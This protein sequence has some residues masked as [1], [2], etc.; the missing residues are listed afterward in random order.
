MS[1]LR[2]LSAVLLALALVAGAALWLQWQTTDNLRSEIQ[3]L[4]EEQRELV[5]LRAENQRLAAT[6]PDAAE[7]TRLRADRSAVMRLRGEIEK[8]K[9]NLQARERALATVAPAAPTAPA[10][11]LAPTLVVNISVSADGSLTSNGQTFDPS[12]LRQQLSTLPRG[13]TFEIRLQQP[14]PDANVPFDKMKQSVDVI[15]DHAKQSVK[16]FGLKMSLKMEAPPR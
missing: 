16:D 1:A 5:R 7:L 3:L 2:S 4:R 6:Q 13:S 14:K 15:A 9:D 12:A 10:A 11:Q 8:T